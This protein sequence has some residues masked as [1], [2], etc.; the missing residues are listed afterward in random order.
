MDVGRI[1][2]CSPSGKQG[3]QDF[4]DGKVRSAYRRLLSVC[5]SVIVAQAPPPSS[6]ARAV[7]PPL[8]P[9][10]AR[11]SHRPARALQVHFVFNGVELPLPT[12]EMAIFDKCVEIQ[13]EFNGPVND[14]NGHCHLGVYIDSDKAVEISHI[15]TQ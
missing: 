5:L 1:I 7:R 14:I 15:I 9:P 4:V 13:K 12:K 6:R 8:T 3:A 2:V 10:L 11:C